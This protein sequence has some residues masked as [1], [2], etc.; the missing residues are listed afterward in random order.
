[1]LKTILSLA[2]VLFPVTLWAQAPSTCLPE[3]THASGAIYLICMPEPANDNGQ[4]VVFAHGYVDA[5]QP[6]GI[7]YNQITFSDGSTLP[8]IVNS[9]GFGFAMSSY[10]VNG[11]AV[12]Q[13]IAETKDVVDVY[14]SLHGAP[15]R[16]LL[17]GA[18]QGGLIA[19]K[20]AELYPGTYAGA[21]AVCGVVG[22]FVAQTNYGGQWRV[23]WDYFFPGLIPGTAIDV[24]QSVID[25]WNAVYR[26]MI[27]SAIASNPA[28]AQFVANA[29]KIPYGD[30]AN[31]TNALMN[32]SGAVLAVNDA[33]AKLGGQPFDNVG[34]IYTGT[35]QNLQLNQSVARY[36]ADAGAVAEINAHYQTTGS[37]PVPVVTMHTTADPIVPFWHETM[38][39]QKIAANGSLA[40]HTLIPI[41]RY[42]HC[43]FTTTEVMAGFAIL[44]YKVGREDLAGAEALLPT[45]A[46]RARYRE[47]VQR[48]R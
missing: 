11:L 13:G 39:R 29:A 37:L 16:V 8:Q 1:M 27:A 32:A 5:S 20:S 48:Y 21:L 17:T 31:L 15:S 19:A 35:D 28:N 3:G 25:D 34:K 24:P 45:P 4:L 33:I 23:V 43:A 42:G 36:A 6:V 2:A 41:D 26:P 18:S 22:D 38:Y 46:D 14:T 40:R 47:L 12:R 9:L 30:P 44:L 7:P 10:S